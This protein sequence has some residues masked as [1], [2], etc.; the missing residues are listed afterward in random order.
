MKLVKFMPMLLC[1]AAL[2][3]NAE[4]KFGFI[5]PA[6]V[7]EK[8]PQAIAA[9]KEMEKEFSQRELDLRAAA[10]SIQAMEKIYQ[11]DGAIMSAGQQKKMEEDIV[12]KKRKFQFDQQTMQQDLQKRRNQI[13]KQLQSKISKVI[14]EYGDKNGYDFI[15]TEGV[16]YA[17]DSVNITDEILKELSK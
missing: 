10:A 14:R 7:L 8:S 2:G 9:A 1:F 5:N 13:L 6:I 4:G 3:V 16:A 17:N 15:F 12:Q 11:T